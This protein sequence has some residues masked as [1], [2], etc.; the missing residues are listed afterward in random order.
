[1]GCY[2]M[3]PKNV[4]QYGA[5]FK[6]EDWN[7]TDDLNFSKTNTFSDVSML[8]L[9][10]STV[11]LALED[12]LF[13]TVNNDSIS[14]PPQENDPHDNILSILDI[15]TKYQALITNGRGQMTSNDSDSFFTTP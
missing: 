9:A 6:E 1:M 14:K 8:P 12:F 5:P 13:P 7:E 3:G 4:V 10:V 15:M 11:V 2:S